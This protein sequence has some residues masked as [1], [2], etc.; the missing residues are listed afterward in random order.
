MPSISSVRRTGR[1]DC[2]TRW[3][4]SSFSD[5]GSLMFGRPHPRSCYFEQPQ[6]KRLLGN[7]FLQVLRL[8]PELLD[9][10]GRRR[11]CR[12]SGEPALTS[13][14]ELLRPGVI[15][16]LGDALAPAQ[17][18]D[19]CFA[20][21]AVEH[22]ADLLFG[23][24]V[25]SRRPPNVAD[26]VLGRHLAGVG[27]LSHLRSLGATMSQKSSVPQAASLVSQALKPDSMRP[28]SIELPAKSRS[29]LP[30]RM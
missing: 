13:L 2:S 29:C 14:E 15:H 25:L 28:R 23:R 7:D 1:C 27:F 3:M 6:F 16:A 20:A 17:L 9:F 8:A 10:I 12:V 26:K 19:R 5:A 30:S 21:Q 4:I 22:D 18:G 11:T 24:M